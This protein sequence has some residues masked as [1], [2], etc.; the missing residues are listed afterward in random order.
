MYGNSGSLNQ[1]RARSG[2]IGRQLAKMKDSLADPAA[3]NVRMARLGPGW[4]LGSMEALTG[5]I[6]PGVAVAGKP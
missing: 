1:L 5:M 3:R 2:T 4:V 6:N